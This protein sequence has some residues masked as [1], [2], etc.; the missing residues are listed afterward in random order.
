LQFGQVGYAAIA[1]QQIVAVIIYAGI[2]VN[3]KL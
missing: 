1:G 3:L 2:A